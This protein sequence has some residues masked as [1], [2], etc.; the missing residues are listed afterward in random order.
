MPSLPQL[1]S[2]SPRHRKGEAPAID[3]ARLAEIEGALDLVRPAIRDDGG[4]IDLVDVESREGGDVV[5]IRFRGACIAC[6][7]SEMTLRHGIEKHL[8]E[9]VPGVVGV[10]A[11]EK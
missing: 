7:S 8:V 6:P 3:D 5:L 2:A 1:Q 11:V 10:E 9:Q 4:D